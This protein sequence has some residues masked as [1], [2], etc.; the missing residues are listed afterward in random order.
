MVRKVMKNKAIY[1]QCPICKL[2]Y[3]DRE[4]AG[5]CEEYCGKNNACNIEIIKNSVRI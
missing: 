3:K 4:L 1:F 2:Y 5:R